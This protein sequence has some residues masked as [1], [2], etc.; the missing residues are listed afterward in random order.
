MLW[1]DPPTPPPW[2][3]LSKA[4][5]AAHV[6]K[7]YWNRLQKET[8]SSSLEWGMPSSVVNNKPSFFPVS[9]DSLQWFTMRTRP[10]SLRSSVE[11]FTAMYMYTQ[12][13]SLAAY[14]LI[15]LLHCHIC[16]TRNQ[17]RIKSCSRSF[18]MEYQNIFVISFP[19]WKILCCWSHGIHLCKFMN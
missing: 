16:Q 11:W 15:K 1:Q 18:C 2:W 7:S 10:W 4:T 19:S 5:W 3:L 14:M 17:N 13:Q 12:I 9:K 8:H 6:S